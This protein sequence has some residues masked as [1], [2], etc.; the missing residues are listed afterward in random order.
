M[1]KTA[2]LQGYKASVIYTS[3]YKVRN[4]VFSDL[5]GQFSTRSQQDKKYI[6]V[7]VE[8]DIN[9]ILVKP[10]KN[11]KNK[12]LTR[13]YRTMMLRLQRAGMIPRKR[14]LDNEVSEYHKK[15]IKDEYKMQLEL[16]P[17][18]THHRNASEVAI[19]NFKAHFLSI[20]APYFAPSLRYRLLPQAEIKINP[21]GSPM[22]LPTFRHTPI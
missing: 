8:I 21:L 9:A 4:T 13:A 2:T 18:G 12:E 22:Q 19:R 3:V 7:M 11:Y 16:V 14:I 6:M 20:L 17:P 10:I 1:P 5:T 15:I